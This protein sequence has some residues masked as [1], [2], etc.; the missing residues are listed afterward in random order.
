[1]RREKRPFSRDNMDVK[2]ALYIAGGVL[3]LTVIAFVAIFILYGTGNQEQTQLARFNSTILEEDNSDTTEEASSQMGRTVNEMASVEAN[4]I[5]ENVSNANSVNS[6]TT[7]D[8][9]SEN[10]KYAVNTSKTEKNSTETSKNSET[11]KK[12]NAQETNKEEEKPVKDP[13]FKMPVEGE[14]IR[15]FAKDSLVY[16]AT[17]DEW[18]THDGIDIKAEKATVVKASA[19]GTVKSIKNDPR[20]GLTVVIEHVN[21]FT[22]VYSNLL[23]AEFI[24]EGEKVEQGQTIATVGNTA[25]FEIADESHLHFEIRKDNVSIDPE[26]KCGN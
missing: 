6:N 19:D 16:S 9:S 20:Y 15:E 17:L 25:T 1:M 13:E 5:A 23:T 2:K 12:D 21:G 3:A 4:E 14:I 8:T 26:L 10:N 18:V 24:E 7:K 11:A 22:T